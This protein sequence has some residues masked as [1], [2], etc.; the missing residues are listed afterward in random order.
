MNTV[1]IGHSPDPDD[2]FLFYGFASGAV[3]IPD[4]EVIHIVQGIQTLNDACSGS[5]KP[6]VSAMSIH[7]YFGVMS[8]YEMLNVG[9]S[10]GRRYGP[11][12]VANNPF[13]LS[14][15]YGKT[16]ALPGNKTTAW[17]VAKKL[18][19][20]FH[21][22]HMDFLEIEDA[23]RR[24]IVD[25]GVLIHEGQLTYQDRG[26]YLIADL[27]E[28]FANRHRGLPLP[29]GVNCMRRDLPDTLK[30]DVALAF[31]R[32]LAY[33]L[34][35]RS[36]AIDYSLQFARGLSRSRVD[37]FVRMYVNEDSVSLHQDTL[38]SVEILRT[39]YWDQLHENN[40]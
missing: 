9:T 38:E 23:T 33:A 14:Q 37:S 39:Q 40:K 32:S 20:Q 22:V 2:A 21:P 28:M 13:T 19:P 8:T 7:A 34:A 15:I 1:R 27:G 31:E 25:A 18:L 17:L 4:H 12:L 26:L 11:R 36:E 16:V 3:T 29:L 35:N 6:E 30:R 24:G 10:V 5:E